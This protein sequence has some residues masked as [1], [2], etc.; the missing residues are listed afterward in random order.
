MLYNS[1]FLSGWKTFEYSPVFSSLCMS[2][3][4]FSQLIV[5]NLSQYVFWACKYHHISW[6]EKAGSLIS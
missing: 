6:Q 5:Y 3:A 1:Y 2:S 4:F